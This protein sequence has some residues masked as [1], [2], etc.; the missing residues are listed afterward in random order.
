MRSMY[1]VLRVATQKK[2]FIISRLTEKEINDKNNQSKRRE[3]RK[4]MK[5]L[6]QMKTQNNMVYL[7]PNILVFT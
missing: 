5:K 4:K 1:V 3:E 2:E 7:K 6:G